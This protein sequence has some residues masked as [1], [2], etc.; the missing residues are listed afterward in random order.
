MRIL[1]VLSFIGGLSAAEKLLIPIDPQQYKQVS[2]TMLQ[3]ARD[4]DYAAV[5]IDGRHALELVPN[6]PELQ[7][8]IYL[9]MSFAARNLGEV[10]RASDYA[11]LARI[12]DPSIESRMLNE[13]RP[14]GADNSVTRGDTQA[15]I[16]T[17]INVAG[18]AFSAF[19]AIKLMKL[20]L[21]MVKHG[22]APP[23]QCSGSPVPVAGMPQPIP[24]QPFPPQ[25]T[26]TFP[27]QPIPQPIPQPIGQPMPI[28]QP[29]PGQPMP[30]PM[31]MPMQLDVNGMPIQS[32]AN[33]MYPPAPVGSPIYQ[34]PMAPPTS[35]PGWPP[36]PIQP[37]P[38][39]NPPQIPYPQPS[40]TAAPAPPGGF[41]V[42]S[43]N[44]NPNRGSYSFAAPN[45]QA[46]YANAR[47]APRGGRVRGGA[48]EP[49]FKVIHDHSDIGNQTYFARSCGGLLSVSGANLTFT[50]SG[51]EEPRVIPASDI[52]EIRLNSV[53]GKDAGVFHIATRQGLYLSLAPESQDRE[54]AR[55]LIE[56]IRASLNLLE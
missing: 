20:C 26:S 12:L 23:P 22:M 30:M 43:A 24:G 47:Y 3:A 34:P 17:G 42:P 49:V 45:M 4:S 8:P 46:P 39:T 38:A 6:D 37:S 40:V 29:A 19:Q 5:L 55:S 36:P 35:V 52:L 32:G 28:M 11:A 50:A 18:Q 54:Q 14:Q 10:A 41:A 48:N 21:D 44:P 53:I 7:A 1:L 25:P 9:L 27:M 33:V 56:A 2:D 16:T 51:G 31:P 13:P 15:T